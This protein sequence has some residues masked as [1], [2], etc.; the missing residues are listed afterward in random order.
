M[1]KKRRSSDGRTVTFQIDDTTADALEKLEAAAAPG[2]L[3]A[4]SAVIRRALIEVAAK[5]DQKGGK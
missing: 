5:L 4:R 3:R 1:S 2:M